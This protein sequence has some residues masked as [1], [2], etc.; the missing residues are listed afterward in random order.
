MFEGFL[1]ANVLMAK[2]MM[3]TMICDRHHHF[4]HDQNNF[5]INKQKGLKKKVGNV[6]LTKQKTTIL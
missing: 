5:K 1:R 2:M 3:M 6:Q 4:R